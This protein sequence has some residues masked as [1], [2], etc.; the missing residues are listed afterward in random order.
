M[1]PYLT[2]ATRP[3]SSSEQ[4]PPV[5]PERRAAL[6]EHRVV[7][8]AQ[9]E[10]AA[11]LLLVVAPQLQHHQLADRVHEIRRDRTCRA[12]LR[13]A[14]SPPRETPRRGRSA[15][16]AP[17]TGPRSAGGWRR[18]TRARRTS[19]FGELAELD[20]W[21]RRGGSRPRSSSARSSAP[22]LRRTTPA[23]RTSTC[24]PSTR[25]AAGA[26][27]AGSGPG[28]TSWIEMFQSVG[29]LKSRM[30]SFWRSGGHER[31]TSVR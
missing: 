27:S 16:P 23:R 13:A 31:S 25:P 24:A 11:L 17:P 12:R 7:E 18:R 26:G 2:P 8:R 15:C 22:S 14:P 1:A 6:R 20:A 21:R 3:T 5:R 30:C 4:Q 28:Y 29:M 9:R 10:L 19:D